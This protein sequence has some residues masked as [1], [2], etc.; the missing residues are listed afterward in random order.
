ME[1]G[2]AG[3][4]VI[5]TGASRGIGRATALAFAREG[6]HV[7]LCARGEEGLRKA[8]AELAALGGKV[9]AAPC[10]VAD[11]AALAGF[12]DA[13][14]AALGAVHVLVNNTSGFGIGD[15]EDGWRKGFDVDVMGAVRACWKVAPMI[16]EAGGGAIVHVSTISALQ[17]AAA[18]PPY[19]AMKAVLVQ[20]VQSLAVKLARQKI[21]VNCVAP[22]SIEFPGG[23]WDLIKK[24]APALYEGTVKRIPWRRHGTP[25][26]V[27]RAIVFV[28]SDAASW[29]TGQTLVVDGGQVLG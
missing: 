2:L 15:D 5:V 10:D 24:N 4:G 6:A 21:R 29:I 16:A 7:A 17:A 27:A 25:E 1:L 8:E 9:F 11:A 12:L 14:R 19:G 20:H 18:N 22:G 26:E 23:A 28:A 13:S 3:K